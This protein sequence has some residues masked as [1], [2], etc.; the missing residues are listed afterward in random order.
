MFSE[1]KTKSNETVLITTYAYF[2]ISLLEL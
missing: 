2:I 1:L